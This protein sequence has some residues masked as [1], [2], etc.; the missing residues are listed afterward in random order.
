MRTTLAILCATFAAGCYQPSQVYIPLDLCGFGEWGEGGN[1]GATSGDSCPDPLLG[2]DPTEAPLAGL[3]TTDADVAGVVVA[4]LDPFDVETTCE[5]VIMGF[6]TGPAPCEVPSA[7]DVVVFDA[8]TPNALG[9]P[10][11]TATVP[12]NDVEL[13]QTT[14]PGIVKARL[15]LPTS[16]A[17]G[18]HPFVGVVVR[19]NFC[20]AV[21]P[22]CDPARAMR[23][24]AHPPSNGWRLLSD[25]VPGEPGVEGALYF[26]LADCATPS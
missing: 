24:R 22:A 3:A 11:I 12:L 18:L 5:T 26:G 10:S 8:S 4:V 21:M 14:T 17:A 19:E 16:H 13:L 15:H 1:G 9:T 20:P 6:A 25:D 2:Y 23:Y 7:I